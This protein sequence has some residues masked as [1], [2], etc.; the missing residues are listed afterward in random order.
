MRIK[1]GFIITTI[2]GRSVVS[3]DGTQSITFNGIIILNNVGL[4]IWNIL[5]EECTYEE[6]LDKLLQ[7]Y[8]VSYE[9]LK[10]D[11]DSFLSKISFAL[12]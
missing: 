3:L 1:E 6:L 5:K 12:E 4:D 7:K 8:K 2:D 9:V 10:K 11:V